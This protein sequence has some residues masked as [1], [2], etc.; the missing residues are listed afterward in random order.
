MDRSRRGSNRRSVPRG[1]IDVNVA[2]HD[3]GAGRRQSTGDRVSQA[4]CRARAGDQRDLADERH[5]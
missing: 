1:A 3:L 4:S 5:T 2:K